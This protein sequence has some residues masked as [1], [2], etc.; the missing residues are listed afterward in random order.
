MAHS[1]QKS[2]VIRGHHVY[3]RIWTPVIGEVLDA[4]RERNNSSDKHAVAVTR[5]GS[6][7]GHVPREMS[8]IAAYFLTRGGRITAE[9]TGP[10]KYGKGLEV[11]CM[12]T[13]S[14]KKKIVAKL[15]Q[16]L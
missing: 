6:I 7:V 12:Y 10:R 5:N 11:P 1:F 9:V 2:S 8:R 15:E 3:K 13:F 14:G 16:L 4:E